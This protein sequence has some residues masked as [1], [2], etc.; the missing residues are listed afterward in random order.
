MEEEIREGVGVPQAKLEAKT[1][2]KQ[3]G[4]LP[5]PVGDKE[6]ERGVLVHLFLARFGEGV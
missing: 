1:T 2:R 5:L 6:D 3:T 4:V